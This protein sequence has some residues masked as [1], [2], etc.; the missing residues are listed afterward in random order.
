[1]FLM[2]THLEDTIGIHIKAHL[3]LRGTT[4]SPGKIGE[5]ELAQKT[6][7]LSESTFTLK[8]LN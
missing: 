1:M 7:V 4:G 6:V 2:G 8:N 5:L 3:D